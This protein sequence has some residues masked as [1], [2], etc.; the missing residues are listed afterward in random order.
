MKAHVRK[1]DLEPF[2]IPR[3]KQKYKCKACQQEWD[4]PPESK[5]PGVRIFFSRDPRDPQSCPEHCKTFAE[6]VAK[7]LQPK[8]VNQPSAAFRSSRH[9]PWVLLYD[10]TK[11]IPKRR[12]ETTLTALRSG[13]AIAVWLVNTVSAA[14]VAFLLGFN[15]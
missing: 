14:L 11:A 6:L 15:P 13:L 7:D 2:S 5:C 4:T 12:S 3:S 9:G 1:H 10:E 8:D